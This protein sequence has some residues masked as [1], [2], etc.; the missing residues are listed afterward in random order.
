MVPGKGSTFGE[1]PPILH[2]MAE[3]SRD[4]RSYEADRDA[5][6]EATAETIQIYADLS[7]RY[8]DTIVRQA[9]LIGSVDE[10]LRK[11]R[12]LLRGG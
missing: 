8:S 7:S 4:R 10:T 12:E 3:A 1:E 5:L 2:L 9:E 6:V 11:V